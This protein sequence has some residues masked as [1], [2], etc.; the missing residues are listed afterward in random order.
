M[1]SQRFSTAGDT[2]PERR[3]CASS[4][5]IE[6]RTEG[7]SPRIVGYAALFNKRSINFGSQDY[8][9]FEVIEP[10][11]FD[12]VTGA[13]VRAIIDHKGGIQTL[14]RTKSGTLSILQDDLGLRFEIH[15]PKTQAAA[16]L[17]ELIKRGDIDQAS[18]AFRVKPQG[19]E[20][21][22]LDDGKTTIRTIKRGGINYLEDISPV[23]FPA[24]QDTSVTLTRSQDLEQFLAVRASARDSWRQEARSRALQIALLESAL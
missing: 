23:T 20:Y 1:T 9:V 19:D 17:I 24:Y 5:P 21:S 13:D 15:P 2:C 14:G 22:T 6:L 4:K 16:D 11:A 7:D 10:G 8:P 12:E 3:F 18:F